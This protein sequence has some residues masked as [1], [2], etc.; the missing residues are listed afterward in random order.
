MSALEKFLDELQQ[1]ENQLRGED[2]KIILDEEILDIV[3]FASMESKVQ[4]FQTRLKKYPCCSLFFEPNE[5]DYS[6][7]VRVAV[8]R[9]F[10]AEINYNWNNTLT[11]S[12]IQHCIDDNG[13]MQLLDIPILISTIPD[14]LRQSVKYVCGHFKKKISAENWM[15]E[16]MD[17]VAELMKHKE[18]VIAFCLSSSNYDEKGHLKKVYKV[19]KTIGRIKG[20][21]KEMPVGSVYH[22]KKEEQAGWDSSPF[23][24]GSN[25]TYVENVSSNWRLNL[26]I[27]K[28]SREYFCP[29]DYNEDIHEYITQSLMPRI[30][31]GRITQERLNRLNAIVSGTNVEVETF[32]T[33]E[34]AAYR[35]FTPVGY[36]SWNEYLDNW[37]VPKI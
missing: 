7:Q 33:T 13:E 9:Q 17:M 31:W 18:E 35:N 12:Y 4:E 14:W 26:V 19:W 27:M 16:I 15:D 10:S 25:G 21:S 1:D 2:G 24:H 29:I 36:T 34:G 5:H 30:G 22:A 6:L 3:V 11:I 28:P 20:L 37:I 32:D 23:F 8:S